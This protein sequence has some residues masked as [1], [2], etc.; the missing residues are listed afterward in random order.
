MSA[1]EASSE[2][3]LRLHALRWP[4][5][6]PLPGD[7]PRLTVGGLVLLVLVASAVFAPLITH[8]SP[9]EQH[10]KDIFHP[11][12]SA[13]PLG[14]DQLG[15]DVLSRALYGGR[16]SL[17][18]ALASVALSM[19]VGV[20]AG[21]VAGYV[22][23]WVDGVVMRV[24]DGIMVF[25]ELV[26]ALA[27]TYALGPSFWNVVTAI[28]VVNVPKFARVVRGQVL[29]LRERDFIASAVVAGASRTRTMAR[30]LLPN[31]L[32]VIVVQAALTGGMAIFT[33]ASLSFLGLGLPPPAPDWGGMLK[34]GYLYL[35]VM[36][37]QALVPGG[38]IFAAM[39][40]FNLL[41]DGLRDLFDP[42]T[43]PRSR[44]RRERAA[45]RRAGGMP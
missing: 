30:H 1:V 24:M 5:W 17:G 32:E 2:P 13:Y 39:L 14:T 28:A 23:R 19:V 20:I 8:T 34:D 31:V 16:L 15:R 22:G 29:S 38:F 44:M 41:G 27:I 21:L 45:R 18:V 35:G 26:L 43:A 6:L 37:L 10:L 42:R 3:R 4:S 33:A 36:P 11:P 25:P 12:G 40:S 7:Y 9:T